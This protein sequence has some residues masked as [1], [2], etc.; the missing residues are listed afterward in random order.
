EIFRLL[1]GAGLMI[2]ESRWFSNLE[3]A[4]NTGA[5]SIYV[6]LAECWRTERFRPGDRILL[7]VPESGRFSF[8][9]AQLTCVG[10]EDIS[11]VRA[12][13]HP[14]ALPPVHMKEADG[15]PRTGPA[16]AR[17][18][19]AATLLGDLAGVWGDFEVALRDVPIVARIE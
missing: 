6:A 4:G 16:V 9:F 18:D 10:P 15:E 7:I 11:D 19:G 17:T 1:T 14:A 8:A 2:D 3:T 5:A 13:A 12:T